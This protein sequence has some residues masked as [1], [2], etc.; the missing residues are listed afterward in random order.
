MSDKREVPDVTEAARRA[1]FGKLPERIRLEDT[2]EERAAIAPDPAKDTYNP[3][4]W[5]VRYC[6]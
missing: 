3:D 5:L 2:V 1:R 6:L 4:E